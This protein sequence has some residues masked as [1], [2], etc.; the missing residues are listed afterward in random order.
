M[1][2][3]T[4]VFEMAPLRCIIVFAFFQIPVSPVCQQLLSAVCSTF[5]LKFYKYFIPTNLLTLN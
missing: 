5:P 2:L 1:R 4:D 3:C